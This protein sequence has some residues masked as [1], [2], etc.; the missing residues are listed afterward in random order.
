LLAGRKF[1]CPK[2]FKT[3]KNNKLDALKIKVK[4]KVD[5]IQNVASN[6][7]ER[8]HKCLEQEKRHL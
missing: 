2:D 5:D 3:M 8:M 7:A 1:R 4:F 6:A